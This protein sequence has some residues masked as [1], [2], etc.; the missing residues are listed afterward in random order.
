MP[1]RAIAVGVDRTP[2]D[3]IR[4]GRERAARV[5]H[6]SDHAV[7]EVVRK[8]YVDLDVCQRACCAHLD[9]LR[10]DHLGRDV[11]DQRIAAS[12]VFGTVA[13]T[14]AIRIREAW[15]RAVAIL[16]DVAQSVAV[17]VAGRVVDGRIQSAGPLERVAHA[18]GI[19]IGRVRDELDA[20]VQRDLPTERIRGRAERAFEVARLVVDEVARP[21]GLDRDLHFVA[22]REIAH[23]ARDRHAVART[24]AGIGGDAAHRET[25]RQLQIQFCGRGHQA[26]A[27]LR[28]TVR[29][30][31][32]ER[33]LRAV[34][35]FLQRVVR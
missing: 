17:R 3:D 13:R 10:H 6:C 15:R 33:E 7:L 30:G 34:R 18:V 25:G 28:L 9:V 1:D 5:G 22:R 29:H 19:G 32:F 21:G 4:T 27:V 12:I 26:R 20:R 2:R 11:V 24:L 8:R 31:Y 14:V 35:H 23:R 16:V